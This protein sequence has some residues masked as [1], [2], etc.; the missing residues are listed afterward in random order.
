VHLI[1]VLTYLLKGSNAS[2][3]KSMVADK[4]RMRSAGDFSMV[5]VSTF[6]FPYTVGSVI[7]MASGS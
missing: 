2:S 7:E 4:E 3:I 5:G 1:N 6:E